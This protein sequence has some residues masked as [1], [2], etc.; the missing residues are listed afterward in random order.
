MLSETDLWAAYQRSRTRTARNALVLYYR[1]LVTSVARAAAGRLP[2]HLEFAELVAMGTVGLIE[3]VERF[4]PQT[5]Y[6]FTTFATWRMRGAILDGLRAL[7]GASRLQ[8]RRARELGEIAE[9]LSQVQR[10]PVA[11]DEA[12]NIIGHN[13]SRAST[14]VPQTVSWEELPGEIPTVFG[15][16]ER[17]D[18]ELLVADETVLNESERTTV[19]LSY[20]ADYSLAEIG[21]LLG[22]TESRACQVRKSALAKLRTALDAPSGT[23]RGERQRVSADGPPAPKPTAQGGDSL[24]RI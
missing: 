4:D 8:R 23:R 20:F 24:Q 13:A 10:R 11:L 18:L 17:T 7:D 14:L 19:Y 16:E 3:A 21:A 1:P 6:R 22:V 5:G 15:S 9:M 2:R 12:A